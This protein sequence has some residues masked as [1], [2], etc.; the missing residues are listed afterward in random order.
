MEDFGED[1]AANID[2]GS[3]RLFGRICYPAV[4]MQMLRDAH[5][6]CGQC[7][8]QMI[9][10]WRYFRLGIMPNSVCFH[11][12][13]LFSVFPLSESLLAGFY[14][15][16]PPGVWKYGLT[17]LILSLCS[18]CPFFS[19]EGVAFIGLEEWAF[20]GRGI[21]WSSAVSPSFW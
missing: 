10:D 2:C 19:G 17:A 13:M 11:G 8:E 18:G 4:C 6:C 12:L 5:I 16:C 9:K 7:W 14:S 1:S 20:S 21:T 3:I 15:S